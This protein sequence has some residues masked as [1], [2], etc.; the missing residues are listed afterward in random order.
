M[1]LWLFSVLPSQ[2]GLEKAIQQASRPRLAGKVAKE[3]YQE[4]YFFSAIVFMKRHLAKKRPLTEDLEQVFAELIL[5]EGILPFKNLSTSL[6]KHYSSSASVN[7]ILAK[8]FFEKGHYKKISKA[9]GKVSS[10]HPL[11]A[12]ALLTLGAASG[13]LKRYT[14]AHQYYQRCQALSEGKEGGGL[15]SCLSHEARLLYEQRRYRKALDTYN[16]IPKTSYVWP[17]LLLEKAWTS[18][19]LK[20]YNRALG[21]LV[22]YKS[23]LLDRYSF[24][25]THVLRA[26]SYFQLCLWDE[27][28]KVV[29][30]HHN[31]YVNHSKR[32]KK[33]WRRHRRSSSAFLKLINRS[34]QQLKVAH[35]VIHHLILHIGKRPKFLQGLAVLEE[36]REEKKRLKSLPKNALTAQLK[37]PLVKMVK[38]YEANLNGRVKEQM[39][40]MANEMRLL[41]KELSRVKLKIVSNKRLA[42]YK[43]ESLS[44]GRIRGSLDH[45]QRSSEEHFYTFNGEFWGDELGDYSFGLKSACLTPQKGGRG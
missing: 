31:V 30:K 16:T 15:E 44:V 26:L 1:G 5:K 34:S 21:L 9:L 3:L 40:S 22:T 19:Q 33:I 36:L 8:R 27:S 6:L 17:S 20:D 10:S 18:Y 32:L 35:P 38:W 4:S 12:Q 11:A 41:G 23:P 37:R 43:S 45:V 14:K 2:G 39:L 29:E 13:L 42:L 28:G 24:P 7:F 25:E